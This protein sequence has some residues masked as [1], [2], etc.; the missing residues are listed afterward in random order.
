MKSTG[1]VMGIDRG[2][3]AAFLKSQ[4]GAGMKPP[5]SG[6]LFVSVKDTDK[7]LIVPAVQTL[8]DKGF[9]VIA[10]GGTQ[11]YLAQQGVDVELV[12]KVA[13]GRPH[14]VDTII[15]GDVQLIFNT[16]EGAVCS[17]ASR[18]VR[19]HSRRS[20]LTTPPLRHALQWRRR[21]RRFHPSSLKCV[22][23]KTIIAD[24]EHAYPSR[25]SNRTGSACR[26]PGSNCPGAE[27]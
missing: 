16:T 12:N 26:G 8:L 7:P 19:R 4:L 9:R 14:V 21:S 2:F 17:T 22:R 11:S 24:E 5:Q 1:E 27:L 15:D 10:T 13:E 23:C 20:C 6:T 3:A 18:S 25:N